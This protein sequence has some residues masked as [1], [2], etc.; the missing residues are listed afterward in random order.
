MELKDLREWVITPKEECIIKQ[1]FNIKGMDV[2][3]LSF[4]IEEDKNTL[5]VIY[6]EEDNFEGELYQD[7]EEFFDLSVTNRQDKLKEI[8]QNNLSNSFHINEMEIQDQIISFN[9]SSFSHMHM[10]NTMSML[11]LGHFI[12]R[13]VMP[14]TWDD[15]K[16]KNL[17]IGQFVQ[18]GDEKAPTIDKSKDLDIS[19]TI[20]TRIREAQIQHSFTAKIGKREEAEKIIYYDE[21][22]EKKSCFYINE[23]S[24]VNLYED[25]E[26]SLEK[27]EDLK[28]R[29]L[30]YKNVLEALE[31][32]Y[33]KDKNL[34]LIK[35]ETEDDRQ[36][37]FYMK[38]YLDAEIVSGSGS[39]VIAFLSNRK[40]KG[41]KG[42]K[43]RECI[44]QPIDKDFEGSLEIELFSRYIEIPEETIK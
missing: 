34:A 40:E 28:L 35:Y 38:D 11:L 16:I 25:L 4:T 18:S 42:Y 15:K 24:S 17:V 19:F 43:L 1:S 21:E 5:W 10:E 36:L 33:P 44:L 20:S 6:E 23:I 12:E 8:M 27:I 41:V 37:N 30:T 14:R 31:N 32:T 13:E 7:S 2:Y 26:K 22:F 29:E 9:S 3:L 39:S